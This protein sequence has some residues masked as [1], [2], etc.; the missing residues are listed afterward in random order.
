MGMLARELAHTTVTVNAVCAGYADTDI[1]AE[2][3]GNIVTETGR[4]P[5]QALRELTAHN[6]QGRLVRPDEVAA[7]VG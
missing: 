1:V 2:A 7:T 5:E 6:P 4:T 3:V